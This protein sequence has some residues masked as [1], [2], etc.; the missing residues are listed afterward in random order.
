LNPRD[1]LALARQRDVKLLR[2][3]VCDLDGSVGVVRLPIGQLNQAIFET[4]VELD[5]GLPGRRLSW[6]PGNVRLVPDAATAILDPFASETTLSLLCCAWDVERGETAAA[7][8]RQMLRRA[9]DYVAGWGRADQV[10]MGCSFG[11]W[12]VSRGGAHTALRSASF[13]Q[14]L[15]LAA[16]LSAA[17][18]RPLPDEV[19]GRPERFLSTLSDAS[20]AD[21]GTEVAWR[22]SWE[23]FAERLVVGCVQAGLPVHDYAVGGTQYGW[24]RLRTSVGDPLAAADAAVQIRIVA[25]QLAMHFGLD[26]SPIAPVGQP[27]LSA[28]MRLGLSSGGDCLMSG[29][30]YGGLSDVGLAAVAGLLEHAP[31]LGGQW[32]SG[33][34]R[35]PAGFTADASP[36]LQHGYS[37]RTPTVSVRVIAE[38]A[39]PAKR[40]LELQVLALDANPYWVAATSLMAMIDGVQ[41][42]R[43]PGPPVEFPQATDAATDQQPIGAI[44][45]AGSVAAWDYLLR[46]DILESGWLE[47]AVIELGKPAVEQ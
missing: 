24:F 30:G 20:T 42:R 33:R 15:A 28:A 5:Q 26:L 25:D 27:H 19:C 22:G 9:V 36:K 10:W 6:M 32:P 16:E 12:L 45:H 7:D 8:A 29:S 1:V 31:T 47:N 44:P 37:L 11:A 40:Q 23:A 38:T 2:L 43:S 46:G 41:S 4:G 14:S 13:G 3:H 35:P 21:D 39:G 18:D 34:G 17:T